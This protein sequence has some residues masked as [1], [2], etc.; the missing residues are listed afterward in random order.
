M[1]V[2]LLRRF[3]S[4]DVNFQQDMLTLYVNMILYRIVDFSMI[5]QSNCK[6]ATSFIL[7]YLTALVH[8]A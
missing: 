7:C 5:I 8:S 1:F 3:S 2:N 6:V 4:D